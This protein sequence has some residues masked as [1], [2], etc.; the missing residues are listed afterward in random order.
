MLRVPLPAPLP[1]P[2][3]RAG[4][5]QGGPL[6]SCGAERGS[7]AEGLRVRIV[8]APHYEARRCVAARGT[9]RDETLRAPQ[10]QRITMYKFGITCTTHAC[11]RVHPVRIARIRCPRFVPRVGLPR[12]R[13]LIG[14]LTAALRF[15]K[16]WVRNDANLGLRTGCMYVSMLCDIQLGHFT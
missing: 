6:S 8:P 7:P 13:C 3:G 16:G 4:D 1:P 10:C 9:V 15:S 5:E 14:S 12:N 2:L 11:I